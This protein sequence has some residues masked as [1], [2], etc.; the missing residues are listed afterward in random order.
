MSEHKLTAVNGLTDIIAAPANVFNGISENVKALWLPLVILIVATAS[1]MTWFAF[2][3]DT[4]EMMRVMLVQSNPDVLADM[5]DSM[6]AFQG[7]FIKYSLIGSALILPIMLLINAVFYLLCANVVSEKDTKFGQWFAL[8]VWVSFPAI[9]QIILKAILFFNAGAGETLVMLWDLDPWSIAQVLSMDMATS[10]AQ[11]LS[12][13]DPIYLWTTFLAIMGFRTI[14]QTGWFA[15][16]LV[17][18]IPNFIY[19]GGSYFISTLF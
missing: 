7:E 19:Y 10:G 11:T 6:L 4:Q 14:A 2:S 16:S 13:I 9:F 17:I 8:A 3:T 12:A 18:L 1:F 15:A 5:D